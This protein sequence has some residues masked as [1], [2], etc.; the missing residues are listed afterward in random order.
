MSGL[1]KTV[2]VLLKT[3]AMTILPALLIFVIPAIVSAQSGPQPEDIKKFEET[4]DLV[5]FAVSAY[6]VESPSVGELEGAFKTYQ[7]ASRKAAELTALTVDGRRIFGRVEIAWDFNGDTNLLTHKAGDR[8]GQFRT[9]FFSKS[10]ELLV[11]LRE[12]EGESEH[13]YRDR[14]GVITVGIGHNASDLDSV[15]K[16][17]FA[18]KTDGMPATADQ[19]EKEWAA[20]RAMPTNKKLAYY[21]DRTTLR[22]NS[23]TIESIFRDD[24]M[25][26]ESS[27]RRQ[28]RNYDAFPAPARE[29]LLDMAYNLGISG[30]MEKFPELV[31]AVRENRWEKVG[32]ESHREGISG[33]RNDTVRQ[34]FL[35]AAAASVKSRA[36]PSPEVP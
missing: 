25:Q 3:Q 22:L 31:K 32:A 33:S 21:E 15:K 11:R 20:V 4:N 19:I 13:F 29:G 17:P 10:K 27:L 16:L 5:G 8:P 34:L 14:K 24:V 26:T 9:S 30:L 12:A 28:F 7:Q 2:G 36:A 18:R 23:G 1:C 35:D 6:R